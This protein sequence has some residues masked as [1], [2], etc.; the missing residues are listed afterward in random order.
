LEEVLGRDEEGVLVQD[1]ANENKR[2]RSHHVHHDVSAKPGEIVHADDRIPRGSKVRRRLVFE[3][4]VDPG[5]GFKRPF[6][7]CDKPGAHESLQ[8]AVSPNLSDQLQGP[9]LIE[10]AITQMGAGPRP[11]IKLAAL[12]SGVGIDAGGP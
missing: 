9:V 7:V 1:A 12:L 5:A 3:Q 4:T 6:H 2:M 10:E 11:Q 8:V